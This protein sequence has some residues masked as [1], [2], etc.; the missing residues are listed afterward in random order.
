MYNLVNFI[1]FLTLA[2]Y[3][4]SY[5][6]AEISIPST[7]VSINLSSHWKPLNKQGFSQVINTVKDKKEF[8][9]VIKAL[10]QVNKYAFIKKHNR[11]G[12]LVNSNIMIITMQLAGER[13]NIDDI[14]ASHVSEKNTLPGLISISQDICPKLNHINFRCLTQES[15]RGSRSTTQYHYVTTNNDMYIQLS[16]NAATKEEINGIV[17][18]ISGITFKRL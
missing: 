6:M 7:G 1:I 18:I 15:K 17:N 8:K 5:G 12:D 9:G 10:D 2:V 4:F 13:I 11:N 16:F 3:P 14:F